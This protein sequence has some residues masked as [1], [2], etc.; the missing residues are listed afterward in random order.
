VIEI[1]EQL[2]KPY[3]LPFTIVFGLLAVY[4]LISV[5]GVFDLDVGGDLDLDASLEGGVS[6][7]FRSMLGF[8]NATD[9]PIMIILIFIS[10][11]GLFM[12]V[13]SNAYLNAG[14]SIWLGFGLMVVNFILA[15]VITAFVTKPFIPLFKMLKDDDE[16]RIPIIGRI[17]VVKSGQ[18]T[19]KFGQVEVPH[20]DNS[21]TLLNCVLPEHYEPLKKGDKVLVVEQLEKEQKFS[22]KPAA[23]LIMKYEDYEFNVFTDE[24][25]DAEQVNLNKIEQ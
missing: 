20:Q 5:L 25:I 1:L 3:N 24:V 13:V 12:N 6:G 16:D 14:E 8:L 18:I 23:E 21:P 15:S 17:G 10:A 2:I 4:T 11:I 7:W 19:S 9:I 22:V